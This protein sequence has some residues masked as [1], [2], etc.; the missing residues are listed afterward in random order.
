MN[1]S[2]NVGIT[3]AVIIQVHAQYSKNCN[4]HSD[5]KH[6]TTAKKNKFPKHPPPLPTHKK[7]PNKQTNKKKKHFNS[8]TAATESLYIQFSSQLPSRQNQNQCKDRWLPYLGHGF[9][10]W[11]C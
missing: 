11:R 7:N 10:Q 6:A 3:S 8:A 1:K 9:Q 2:F 5:K 4:F